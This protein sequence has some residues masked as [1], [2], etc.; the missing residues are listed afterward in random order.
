RRRE[1]HWELRAIQLTDRTC[2]SEAGSR[3][4][5]SFR[6]V[7]LT[8]D[9]VNRHLLALAEPTQLDEP[10]L[11]E[12][13]PTFSMAL[14]ARHHGHVEVGV[15]AVSRKTLVEREYQLLLRRDCRERAVGCCRVE[16]E[17]IEVEP[18][19][20]VRCPHRL[21]SGRT[22]YLVFEQLVD[23]I[24]VGQGTVCVVAI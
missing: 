22:Q 10:A 24:D 4:E 5:F 13:V 7:C 12:H 23:Q 16:L 2:V 11:R 20:P 9:V 6:A 19:S 1:G 18:H 17:G 21:D 14:L 3:R 8:A 15:E